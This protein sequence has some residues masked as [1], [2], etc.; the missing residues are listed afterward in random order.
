V[1]LMFSD[2]DIQWFKKDKVESINEN[3]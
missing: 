2:G 1:A 3:L